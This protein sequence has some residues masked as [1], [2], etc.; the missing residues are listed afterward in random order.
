MLNTYVS[1]I[2]VAMHQFAT[3][4]EMSFNHNRCASK[5]DDI[6]HSK[7]D[8][9][10]HD[11]NN[12]IEPVHANLSQA[13]LC[14]D[15]QRDW[16]AYANNAEISQ[17]LG[18]KFAYLQH[19]LAVASDIGPCNDECVFHF[20]FSDCIDLSYIHEGE[21]DNEKIEDEDD[22]D[23]ICDSIRVTIRRRSKESYVQSSDQE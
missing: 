4:S 3:S 7:I 12:S 15:P 21:R 1:T 19:I 8:H 10:K 11:D 17:R 16:A 22:E 14:H 5:N 9:L 13:L 20:S 6:Q 2:K 18:V 23:S